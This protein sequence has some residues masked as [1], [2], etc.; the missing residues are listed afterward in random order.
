MIRK[1][2][3]KLFSIYYNITMKCVRQNIYA[4][5]VSKLSTYIVTY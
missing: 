2:S 1:V 5:I 3:K 4:H